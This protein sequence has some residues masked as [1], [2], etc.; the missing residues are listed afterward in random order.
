L[1]G[2]VERSEDP[3]ES[4]LRSCLEIGALPGTRDPYN[5][6][7]QLIIR[8]FMKELSQRAF[9]RRVSDKAV[10]QLLARKFGVEPHRN[11][12]YLDGLTAKGEPLQRRGTCY[13]LPPLEEARKMFDPKAS[14]PACNG[15]E[16][17]VIV[18]GE[19]HPA[20]DQNIPF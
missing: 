19:N 8:N 15:W 3:A 9:G 4:L 7:E 18:E 11:G 10:A 2:Q 20:W 1:Q 12:Y 14:W 13:D 6:P 17:E 16:Y 5:E